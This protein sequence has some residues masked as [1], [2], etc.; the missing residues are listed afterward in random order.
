M[1]DGVTHESI[2]MDDIF[3]HNVCELDDDYL[4]ERENGGHYP[5]NDLDT[6]DELH[7]QARTND[8]HLS[9]LGVHGPDDP[10]YDGATDGTLP[11]PLEL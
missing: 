1:I 9:N 7:V 10:D 2:H 4:D 11:C 5:A 6:A 8:E 3:R